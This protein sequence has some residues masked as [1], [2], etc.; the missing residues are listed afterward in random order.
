VPRFSSTPPF[1]LL[2]FY[3]FQPFFTLNGF[4]PSDPSR[5]ISCESC[6][7]LPT[8]AHM[9]GNLSFSPVSSEI[10]CFRHPSGLSQNR[11]KGKIIQSLRSYKRANVSPGRIDVSTLHPVFPLSSPSRATPSIEPTLFHKTPASFPP[12]KSSSSQ[13]WDLSMN[14]PR[15]FEPPFFLFP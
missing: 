7:T 12:L 5:K 1:P 15:R 2:P 3:H 13:V 11:P 8:P 10:R 4:P 6:E 9:V 14:F